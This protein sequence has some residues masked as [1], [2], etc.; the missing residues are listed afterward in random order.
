MRD[1]FYEK[2]KSE[3]HIN[4]NEELQFAY[5]LYA[6]IFYECKDCITKLWMIP[7]S[8]TNILLRS[9]PNLSVRHS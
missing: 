5:I 2:D 9:T 1:H 7:E 3:L 8:I 4:L 6:S